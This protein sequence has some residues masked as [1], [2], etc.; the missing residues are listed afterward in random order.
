LF[1]HHTGLLDVL[2]L[3]KYIIALAEGTLTREE[4][5]NDQGHGALILDAAPYSL[6]AQDW[7]VA[8]TGPRREMMNTSGLRLYYAVPFGDMM[9]TGCFGLMAAIAEYVPELTEVILNNMSSN[10]GIAPWD[11]D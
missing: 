3:E 9:L 6:D 2:R 1:E 4:I 5:Y 11:L 7:N 10:E 8:I